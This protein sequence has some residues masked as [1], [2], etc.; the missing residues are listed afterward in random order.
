MLKRNVAAN[1]LPNVEVEDAALSDVDGR[2]M[3]EGKMMP[4]TTLLHAAQSHGVHA[5]DCLKIDIEGMEDQVLLPFFRDAPQWL[6]PKAIVG[7]HIFT[8]RWRDKCLELGYRE[9]W[10]SRFNSALTLDPPAQDV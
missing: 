2:G 7:E 8:P 9:Q 10:Q 5:I 1:H 3:V 4:T 6:W